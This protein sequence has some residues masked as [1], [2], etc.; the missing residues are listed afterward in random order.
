MSTRCHVVFVDRIGE[1]DNAYI[2][3]V[4]SDGYPEG[5]YGIVSRLLR[6]NK[7]LDE[8]KYWC[9][10]FNGEY[11]AANWVYWCKQEK[12]IGSELTL[13]YGFTAVVFDADPPT[14]DNDGSRYV[15]LG[16]LE[17]YLHGDVEYLYFVYPPHAYPSRDRSDPMNWYVIVAN[18]N[19]YIIEEGSLKELVSQ[20]VTV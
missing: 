7:W 20:F 5:E 18:Y 11:M 13:G 3:Y 6:F 15:P 16:K 10:R 4:H 2:T 14:T 19:G 17:P 12:G 1:Y 8:D 9:K